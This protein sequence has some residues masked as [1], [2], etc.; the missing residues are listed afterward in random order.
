MDQL[1]AFGSSGRGS[2]AG[3]YFAEGVAYINLRA[4][5]LDCPQVNFMPSKKT[6]RG[7]AV[8]FC[9]AAGTAAIKIAS[10]S[11][12]IFTRILRPLG[13]GISCILRSARVFDVLDQRVSGGLG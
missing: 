10:A 6:S 3:K 13:V 1:A 9:A 2:S 8:V 4:T 12:R 5:S 11:V 7:G